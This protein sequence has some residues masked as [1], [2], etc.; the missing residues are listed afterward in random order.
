MKAME[1]TDGD[2]EREVLES[3]LRV[4]AL[5]TVLMFKDGNVVDGT[6]G[7]QPKAELR[8]RLEALL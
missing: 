1:I 6:V 2:F 5:P 4:S 3:A 7:V 8:R